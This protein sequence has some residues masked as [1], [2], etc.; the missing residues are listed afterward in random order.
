MPKS[1]SPGGEVGQPRTA[2][3]LHGFRS[4]LLGESGVSLQVSH[5]PKLQRGRNLLMLGRDGVR[6]LD[7]FLDR[8]AGLGKLVKSAGDQTALEENLRLSLGVA[9]CL[10]QR[11]GLVELGGGRVVLSLTAQKYGGAQVGGRVL[12]VLTGGLAVLFERLGHFVVPLAG[13]AQVDKNLRRLRY[14]DLSG[15]RGVG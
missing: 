13:S 12:R 3:S 4:N 5:H 8:G 9:Q 10:V 15:Q 2:G 1:V 6:Q 14:G 11:I 7:S